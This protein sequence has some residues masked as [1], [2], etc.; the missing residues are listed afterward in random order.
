MHRKNIDP[1]VFEQGNQQESVSIV[2]VAA[3]VHRVA[4]LLT[5]LLFSIVLAEKQSG[6]V[7]EQSV[8]GC[9]NPLGFFA[10]PS[11]LLN[12]AKVE[13]GCFNEWL[14]GDECLGVQNCMNRIL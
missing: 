3:G 4:I 12:A 5:M 11:L 7:L 8:V 6:G 9:I 13:A 10:D 1:M 2:F 14:P